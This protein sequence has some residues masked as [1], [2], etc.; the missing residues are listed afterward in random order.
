MY[1]HAAAWTLPESAAPVLAD[2]IRRAR[3]GKP[4]TGQIDTRLG[5]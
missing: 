3:S 5:Y 1:P 2:N 4:L